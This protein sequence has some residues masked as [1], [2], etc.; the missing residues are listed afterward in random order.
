MAA[1]AVIEGDPARGLD[2]GDGEV[3]HRPL[4][5]GAGARGARRRL[6]RRERGADAG[7]RGAPRRQARLQVAVR[8]RRRDLGEALRRIGEGAAM[9]RTKGEAGTGNIVEAVRH[10]R[11]VIGADPP[12][13]PRSPPEE[14]MARGE[15]AAARRYELVRMVARDG[16]AAGAELRRRRHRDAGR[17]RAVHGARRRGGVRRL[18]HLQERGPGARAR[19]PC[20][21][22][23]HALAT[24]PRRCS[25]SQRGLGEAMRGLDDASSS[26]EDERLAKRGW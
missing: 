12:R 8:V 23:T 20:V 14:L 21:R 25:P 19:A 9:I 6:H 22:A 16:Q 10:M 5:R 26:P 4:R 3:P 2:P 7:R 15:G 1:I 13:S 11:A 24:T 17:R 18:G